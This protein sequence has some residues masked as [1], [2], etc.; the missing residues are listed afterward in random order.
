MGHVEF[1]AHRGESG[2]GSLVIISVIEN[3]N[4]SCIMH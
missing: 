2:L 1:H 3:L 4:V